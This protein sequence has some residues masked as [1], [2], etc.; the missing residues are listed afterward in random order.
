[1]EGSW[2]ENSVIRYILFYI[3]SKVRMRTYELLLKNEKA[4]ASMQWNINSLLI[5]FLCKILFC[6]LLCTYFLKYSQLRFSSTREE[7]WINIGWNP[8]RQKEMFFKRVDR[9]DSLNTH[10][11][12]SIQKTQH[13]PIF[14]WKWIVEVFH[15]YCKR[16][17]IN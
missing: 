4:S 3:M 16:G 9:L 6:S 1:M 2:D 11:I 7:K 15:G 10:S 14:P 12:C 5:K 13:L 17:P 8:R